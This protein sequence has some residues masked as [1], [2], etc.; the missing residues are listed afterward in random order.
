LTTTSLQTVP[1][2]YCQRAAE[3]RT[4][5]IAK[6]TDEKPADDE[7]KPGPKVYHVP[8]TVSDMLPPKASSLITEAANFLRAHW[9]EVR[10]FYESLSGERESMHGSVTLDE[11]ATV[12]EVKRIA[13]ENGFAFL[14]T[15]PTATLRRA[16]RFG[17]KRNTGV[18]V[19]VLESQYKRL[20]IEHQNKQP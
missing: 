1:S 20:R 3:R 13:K 18:P 14:G 2:P 5:H 10:P 15:V 8:A 11:A 9:D 12:F 16:L 7:P 17:Y 6:K 4:T 19:H